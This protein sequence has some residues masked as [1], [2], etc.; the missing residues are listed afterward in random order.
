[1]SINR[2]SKMLGY[3]R[4]TF[5]EVRQNRYSK[6]ETELLLEEF[7]LKKV[8]AIREDLPKCGGKKMYFLIS[9]D[10]DRN[11][12]KF[13]RK[14]FFEILKKHGLLVKKRKKYAKT[15]DSGH[16]LKQYPDLINGLTPTRP[17]QVWVADITYFKTKNGFIYG[18][19]ITDAYSKK[20]MGYHISDDMKAASTLEALIMAL[21]NRMY[22]KALIHHSDRGFQY[23][24]K[25]Y[26]DLLKDNQIRRSVTQDGSPYD[27]AVAERINDIL[28]GEFNFDGIFDNLQQARNQ[29]KNTVDVYNNQ[30]P[31][32]SNHLL[33]PAQMHLQE[34][35]E[36][37]IWRKK[38]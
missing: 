17:E 21:E 9:Q 16:W 34:E 7:I 18:H 14:K 37:K 38:S 29:I 33:T 15:T 1:M 12:F 5:F 22:D 20:I 10:P 27:N 23:L 11:H 2:A 35:L 26:T 31:H 28:K 24:S 4:S 19:L 6:I 32:W 25:L 30:R 13:G 8:K 36:I 3:A